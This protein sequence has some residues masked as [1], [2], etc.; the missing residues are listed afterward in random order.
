VQTVFKDPPLVLNHMQ[1]T[2]EVGAGQ[3]RLINGQTAWYRWGAPGP[4]VRT[5]SPVD[6]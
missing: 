1:E 3:S 5:A 4:R 6:V 2:K